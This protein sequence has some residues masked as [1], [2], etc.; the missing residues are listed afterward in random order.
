MLDDGQNSGGSCVGAD[1]AE[2]Q[3][4]AGATKE[5]TGLQT[6][7]GI[8]HQARADDRGPFANALFHFSLVAFQP[9]FQPVELRPI[10]RQ[11]DSEYSYRSLFCSSH[12]NL[13]RL[14]KLE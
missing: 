5:L 10:R 13:R 8:V 11:A 7:G 1:V 4:N 12:A 3:V 9:L 14:L 6:F 2:N